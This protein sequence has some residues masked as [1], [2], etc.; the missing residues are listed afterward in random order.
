M[1]VSFFLKASHPQAVRKKIKI[2]RIFLF[3]LMLK[4]LA[5]AETMPAFLPF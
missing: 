1:T 3:M 5:I 2:P 4:I